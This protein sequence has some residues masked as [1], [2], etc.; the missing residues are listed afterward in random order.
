[1]QRIAREL[2]GFVSEVGY[3]WPETG[4]DY[5]LR[6]F[7]SEREVEFC[8]HATIAIL[9]DLIKNHAELARQPFTRIVTNKGPLQVE[10]RIQTEDAVF[11]SAPDPV[12]RPAAIEK[13]GL[14]AAAGLDEQAIDDP[15]AVVNAGLETLLVPIK[16]LKAI[17][18][19]AP[20]LETLKAYCQTQGVDIITVFCPETAQAENKF[21][22]RVFAPTFGYLEDPATG[23]GNAAFGHYL[24]RQ[25]LWQGEPL[26]VE[27]NGSFDHPNR[28][29]LMARHADDGKVSVWFG[30]GAMVRIQGEYLLE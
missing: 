5:R 21:R 11:I 10:N 16:S 22:T 23:S 29:R 25:G 9:Y 1:M 18:A 3:L 7:S 26:I 30:G 15:I 17:L 14:A 19:M 4:G 6:Y 24:L 13:P 20:R 2:K 27:Q 12:F 28:I 8:G